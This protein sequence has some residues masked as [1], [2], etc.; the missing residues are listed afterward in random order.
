MQI[1]ASGGIVTIGGARV[2]AGDILRGDA[3]GVIAIPRAR[4]ADVLDAAEEID[5]AEEQMS[6]PRPRSRS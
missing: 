1:A 4:E 2:E 3:D 5:A 6:R